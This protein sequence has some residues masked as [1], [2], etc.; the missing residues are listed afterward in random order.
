MGARRLTPESK[1]VALN[2]V[3][4]SD[5]GLEPAG[6]LIGRVVL[7]YVLSTSCLFLMRFLTPLSFLKLPGL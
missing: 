1:A 5:T 3:T 7:Q 6:R 2:T 4:S